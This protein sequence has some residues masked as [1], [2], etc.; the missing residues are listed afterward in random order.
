MILNDAGVFSAPVPLH[1]GTASLFGAFDAEGDGDQDLVLGTETNRRLAI[2]LNCSAPNYVLG[3][4]N[5]DEKVNISDAVFLLNYI[6]ADG[7]APDPRLRG[8]INSDSLVNISDA[9]KIINYL[10][11][12]EP[13]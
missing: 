9:V 1:I 8:D 6:F 4:C 13:L 11:F 12:G 3:D 2:H 10:F 7:P 5:N